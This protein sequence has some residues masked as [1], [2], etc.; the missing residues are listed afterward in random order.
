MRGG[1]IGQERAPS[2][3]VGSRTTAGGA[4]AIERGHGRRGRVGANKASGD[5]LVRG[6][7]HS[8]AAREAV[9]VFGV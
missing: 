5:G 4:L 1:R 8:Q 3:D 2:S 6:E 7:T 9:R